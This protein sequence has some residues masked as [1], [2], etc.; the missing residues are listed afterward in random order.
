[1]QT[2]GLSMNAF[3]V[4]DVVSQRNQSEFSCETYPN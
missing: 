4:I 1:M 2:N 3:H